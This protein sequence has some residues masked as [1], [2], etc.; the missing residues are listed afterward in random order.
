VNGRTLVRT[1]LVNVPPIARHRDDA[2]RLVRRITRRPFEPEFYAFRTFLPMTGSTVLDIGASHGQAI[3]AF[4]M[5]AERVLV[6]AFEPLPYLAERLA[7]RWR[8]HHDVDVHDFGLSDSDTS[9][10]LHVPSYNGVA[11]ERLATTDHDEVDTWLRH[12]I[13]GFDPDRLSIDTYEITLRRLDDIAMPKADVVK[14]DVRGNEEAV[15]RGGLSYLATHLPVVLVGN[16]DDDVPGLLAPLGYRRTTWDGRRFV[17]DDVS[18][19]RR[20]FYLPPRK[21]PTRWVK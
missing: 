20:S 16:N 19:G 21:P 12:S 7:T 4:R 3:D 8:Y 1:A 14:I 5:M 11:F 18:H 10:K 2:Q 9:V 15:I 13:H 6:I 17:S